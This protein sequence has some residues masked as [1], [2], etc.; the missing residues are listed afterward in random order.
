MAGVSISPLAGKPAPR[1]LLV[2]VPRLVTA[3]YAERP[4]S[5]G[6]PRSA[7]P[8]AP[9][10]IAARPLRAAFNE[11]HILAITQAICE[12]R[13]SQGIDGPLFLGIDT[14]ALSEPARV[15]GA[16]GARRQRGRGAHR[17][18]GRLHADP[19][20]LPRDPHAQPRAARRAW[21]TASSSRPRTIRRKTAASSTT[22]R[23][24]A[25]PTRRV[26][27]WIEKRANELLRR[28][29]AQRRARCP[30]RGRSARRA[31]TVTTTSRP[32]STIWPPWSTWTPSAAQSS[33]S[34]SIPLGGAGVAYW[35]PL[36]ER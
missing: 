34:A 35:A 24:A 22:R 26:T 28:C 21:P 9:R 19:G 8:S 15:D 1:D 4:G 20:H 17:R 13:R 14:H 29:A 11:A 25:R 32:T 31:R 23:T 18:A 16:R 6:A 30:T 12:Y 33:A 36:C 3:Y 2:N 10:A 7:S 5:R 27:G